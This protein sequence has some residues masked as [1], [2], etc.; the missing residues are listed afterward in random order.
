VRRDPRD[1]SVVYF[2]DPDLHQ[3][4][5]IPYRDMSLP[6]ISIW[7]LRDVQRRFLKKEERADQAAIFDGYARM[8]SIEAGS[9][10]TTRTE[11]RKAQRRR[12]SDGKQLLP[13]QPTSSAEAPTIAEQEIRPFE[14]R[15]ELDE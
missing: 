4:F 2:F 8:R 3:H 12:L 1:L 11:R 5:R 13:D 9:A 10:K 6:A 7:E 15:E 14:E